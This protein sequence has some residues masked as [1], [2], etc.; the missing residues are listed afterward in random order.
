M[1]VCMH[2]C[3]YFIRTTDVPKEPTVALITYQGDTLQAYC[4]A[5]GHEPWHHNLKL[6]IRQTIEEFIASSSQLAPKP[7]FRLR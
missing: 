3:M 1:Y 7:H 4:S 6:M 2:Q 5:I